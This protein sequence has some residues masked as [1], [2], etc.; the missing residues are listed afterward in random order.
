MYFLIYQDDQINGI[1]AYALP[2]TTTSPFR[3]RIITM[4]EIVGTLST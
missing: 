4:R 1:G 3:E 2:I